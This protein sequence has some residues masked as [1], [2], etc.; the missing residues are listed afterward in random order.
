MSAF[1]EDR[2]HGLQLSPHLVPEHLFLADPGLPDVEPPSCKQTDCSQFFFIIKS[3]IKVQSNCSFWGK[4]GE[5][6]LSMP[7]QC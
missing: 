3:C 4:I 2:D 7:K 1:S 6:I 5:D